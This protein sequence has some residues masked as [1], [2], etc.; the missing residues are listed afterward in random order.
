MKR[1]R[2]VALF[3]MGTG[4]LMLAACEDPNE[5]VPIKAYDT[6]AACVADGFA[7]NQCAAA[8]SSAQDSYETAYPKYA[9]QFDCEDN[10]GEGKCEPDNPNSRTPSWRPSMV[11]FIIGAMAA[12]RVQP[13]PIV[14]SLNSPT[15]RA[16]AT[17]VPISGRGTAATVPARAAGAPTAASVA[18]AHTQAR[19]GFGSTA[20]RVAGSGSGHSS[21]LG[22]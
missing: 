13:Q 17:G 18:A 12:S 1:S 16:T 15:G 10:A 19:G 9:D 5:L 3:G 20:S 6:V 22:G 4:A 11:G 21:S 7:R 8:H 2:Y 14:S